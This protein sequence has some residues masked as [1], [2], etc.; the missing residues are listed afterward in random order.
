MLIKLVL[1]PVSQT[2][3]AREP[4][5]NRAVGSSALASLGNS[6]CRHSACTL[7][8]LCVSA[9]VQKTSPQALCPLLFLDLPH[10]AH[11]GRGGYEPSID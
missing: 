10:T 1:S 11:V 2:S 9:L 3:L 6:C 4:L 8:P 7:Y 5:G